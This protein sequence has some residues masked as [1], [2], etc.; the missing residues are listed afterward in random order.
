MRAKPKDQSWHDWLYNA[1]PG[2]GRA[3][4]D[5]TQANANAEALFLTGKTAAF[6]RLQSM[7]ALRRLQVR[8]ISQEQLDL[9]RT[10]KDLTELRVF[11]FRGANAAPLGQLSKLEI[12]TFE[13]APKVET[14]AWLAKLTALRVLTLGDLKR[15]TEFSPVGKL[16][17]LNFLYICGGA[18]STQTVTSIAPV[19]QLKK[20]EELSLFAQVNGDDI[21]PL[22]A[23]TWLKRLKVAN[24]FPVE[25]FAELAACLKKTECEAFTPTRTV[26]MG[27]ETYIELIGKPYR[28]FVKGD[29]KGKAAIAKREAEFARWRTHFESTKKH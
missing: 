28:R 21:S 3:V 7:K 8:E 24:N 10:L 18:T 4:G 17:N 23:M 29:P 25:T 2:F 13:W 9:I 14:L 27:D 1:G 26:T 15:V 16:A 19:G 12:L 6:D 20:L 5:L 11:G 22:A